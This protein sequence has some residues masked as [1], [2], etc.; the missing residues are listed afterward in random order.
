MEDRPKGGRSLIDEALE[1]DDGWTLDQALERVR[2]RL[3]PHFPPQDPHDPRARAQYS[4]TNY[5]LL[6]GVLEGVSAQPVAEVYRDLVFAPLGLSNTYVVSRD[7]PQT[8]RMAGAATLWAGAEPIDAP[9][10]LQS[11]FGM[12]STL[13]DQL[14]LV[15]GVVEGR[16]FE[17]GRAAFERMATPFRRFGQGVDPA[18]L[19]RPGWPIEYAHGVMRFQHPPFPP[20]R[21][22]GDVCTFPGTNTCETAQI[23]PIGT[24]VH[25][26]S[27]R[28][29]RQH[30]VNPDSRFAFVET[31]A[32]QPFCSC[33]AR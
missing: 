3:R 21:P 10:T 19:R 20:L 33:T 24:S 32:V 9:V 16:P 7:A 17:G 4:D 27:G 18:A 5:L 29:R 28:R 30:P 31:C 14:A 26:N 1:C 23:S 22:S 12:F 2:S 11:T 6:K 25:S 15:R 13:D 8:E